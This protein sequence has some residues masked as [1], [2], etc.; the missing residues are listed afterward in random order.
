[1]TGVC[2]N[3][4]KGSPPGT[5]R[6]CCRALPGKLMIISEFVSQIIGAKSPVLSGSL[7]KLTSP[8]AQAD[9]FSADGGWQVF[10]VIP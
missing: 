2:L 8:P 7:I 3:C 6:K 5:Y 4:N 10:T 1:M 9:Y